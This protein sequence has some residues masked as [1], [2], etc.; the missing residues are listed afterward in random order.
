M[1][2]ATYLAPAAAARY[3]RSGDSGVETGGERGGGV[4]RSSIP[5]PSY[6]R[7]MKIMSGLSIVGIL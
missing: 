7:N 3:A 4:A 5:F 1:A 2:S 6:Q